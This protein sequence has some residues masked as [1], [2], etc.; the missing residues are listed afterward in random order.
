MPTAGG[1]DTDVSIESLT[2]SLKDLKDHNTIIAES[3]K[4]YLDKIKELRTSLAK[5][6]QSYEGMQE[7]C[8]YMARM[9]SKS[10]KKKRK[11]YSGIKEI[12]PPELKPCLEEQHT[13]VTDVLCAKRKSMP[14]NWM[15][16]SDKVGTMCHTS[17]FNLKEHDLIPDGIRHEALWYAFLVCVNVEGMKSQRSQK[18]LALHK[19]YKSE[20]EMPK[21]FVNVVVQQANRI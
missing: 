6:Q 14:K 11:G 5:V 12:A 8:T 4:Q 9:S 10:N 15:Q 1:R 19:V 20:S 13:F 18:N 16:F 2:T 7:V 3:N 21:L 17:L